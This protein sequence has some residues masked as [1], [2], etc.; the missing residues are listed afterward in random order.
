MTILNN[1]LEKDAAK[2]TCKQSH[3]LLHFFLYGT[4]GLIVGLVLA[5][6]TVWIMMPGMMLSIH[7]SKYASVE[8]TCSALKHSIEDTGWNCPAIRDMNASMAKEG[9]DFSGTVRLVE[10]CKA[11]YARSVLETNPEVSTLMPCAFGV[12][13]GA[14]GHVYISGMNMGLMGKMFGGRIA[15]IMGN[16]VATDEH[17]ILAPVIDQ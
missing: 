13:E 5:G 2:S 1:R 8:E 4:A 6:L 16:K 7:R 3:A 14:D 10:L 12:Y 17:A 15:E 9:V 11:N